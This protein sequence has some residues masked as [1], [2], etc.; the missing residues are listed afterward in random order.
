MAISLDNAFGIHETALKLR[1][2]RTELLAGNLANADTP[3]YKAKDIDFKTA[4]K[5]AGDAG[6][7]S[8]KTTHPAHIGGSAASGANYELYRV[9]HQPT[10]DGNTVETHIE[11]AAF[12]RNAVEY[13]ASLRFLQGRVS[14]LIKAIKG[15]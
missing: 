15:E 10:L 2:R 5:Q 1:A 14:G 8:I 12:A 9:P 3:N 13:Q 11:Q 4:L 6:S 7:A